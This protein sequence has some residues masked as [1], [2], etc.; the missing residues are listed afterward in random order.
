MLWK[1]QDCF[2]S[3]GIKGERLV[4]S[5]ISDSESPLLHPTATGSQ[6]KAGSRS[7]LPACRVVV[8]P[9]SLPEPL[10][11]WPGC[12]PAQRNDRKTGA[13]RQLSGIPLPRP[14]RG[15]FRIAVTQTGQREGGG[16]PWRLVSTKPP[17]QTRCAIR[18]QGA[19]AARVGKGMPPRLV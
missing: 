9:S 2:Q 17:P 15:G 13:L 18:M 3:S 1:I 6:S 14:G 10:D 11:P 19:P 7:R 5:C 4:V 8:P 16:E 12:K